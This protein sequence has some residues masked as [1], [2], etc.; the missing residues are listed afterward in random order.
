MFLSRNPLYKPPAP[1]PTTASSGRNKRKSSSTVAEPV[2]FDQRIHNLLAISLRFSCDN[3]V[4]EISMAVDA[5]CV[6]ISPA[7]QLILALKHEALKRWV[8]PALTRLIQRSKPL[9][10][11]DIRVL[12]PDRTELIAQRREQRISQMST[13]I[14]CP[15]G[16]D[17]GNLA[18]LPPSFYVV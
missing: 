16:P 6:D 2:S 10:A 5:K 13:G 17:T 11:E 14:W 15:E 7:H 3:I 12:G 8:E 1:E 9:S 18:N 4:Q